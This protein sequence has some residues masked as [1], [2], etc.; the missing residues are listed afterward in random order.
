MA[1]ELPYFRFT[2]AEWLNGDI[3]MESYHLKGMFIDI[4]SWYWFKDCSVTKVMIEK[5]FPF[6]RH[7]E[8]LTNFGMIKMDGDNIRIDFL[9]DQ[10]D[11]LSEKRKARQRAGSKGGKQ[12]ASNATAKPKQTPSYKDKDKDNNKDKDK[13]YRAFAHLSITIKE[14]IKIKESGYTKN[15]IDNILD[16]IENYKDNKKYKSLYLTAKKWLLREKESPMNQTPHGTNLGGKPIPE[17]Y[18]QP[19][20]TSMTR[21]EWKNSDEYKKIQDEKGDNN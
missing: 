21:E 8:E 19:S 16:A 13:E 4:C 2:V 18:G 6:S 20:E 15:Q 17:D 3:S 14:C 9:N 1:Q 12:K 10:F 7:I 11:M 5:K